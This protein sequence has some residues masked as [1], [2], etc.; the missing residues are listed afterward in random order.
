MKLV[1]NVCYGPPKWCLNTRPVKKELDCDI[2]EWTDVKDY[3]EP[4]RSAWD[5]NHWRY[6]AHLSHT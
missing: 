5:R 2:K 6:L 3:S 4:K 1:T